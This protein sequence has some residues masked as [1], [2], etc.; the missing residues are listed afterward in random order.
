MMQTI[1]GMDWEVCGRTHGRPDE[2]TATIDLA[3]HRVS[4][5]YR[6]YMAAGGPEALVPIYS[7][8]MKSIGF[9][10]ADTRDA[11][12]VMVVMRKRDP[13]GG[14][15]VSAAML[16]RRMRADG[17]S[18]SLSIPLQWHPDGLLWGDLTMATKRQRKVAGKRGA[19]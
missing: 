13:R 8:K 2:A 6:A 18:G 7:A 4:F 12:A 14:F 9:R 17:Y 3:E 1:A 16:V 19:A 5:N 11:L 10:V 15:R